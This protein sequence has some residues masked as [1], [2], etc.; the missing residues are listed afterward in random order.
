MVL[1]RSTVRRPLVFAP[2][3][4][5]ARP[6]VASCPAL[7]NYFMRPCLET[8]IQALADLLNVSSKNVDF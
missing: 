8:M 5:S 2:M 3:A 6:N 7:L 1:F 4:R